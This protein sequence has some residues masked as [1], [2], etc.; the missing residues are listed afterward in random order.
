[1]FAAQ[2]AHTLPNLMGKYALSPATGCSAQQGALGNPLCQG[3][4]KPGASLHKLCPH[5]CLIIS[6]VK[7]VA[8]LL[9]MC[10]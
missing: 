7:S 1:M 3:A 6:S 10:P 4:L 9:Y 5:L 8:L 2:A